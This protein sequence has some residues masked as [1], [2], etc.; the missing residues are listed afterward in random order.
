MSVNRK[1][2]R[3]IAYASTTYFGLELMDYAVSQGLA[4]MELYVGHSRRRD[5][6]G[7]LMQIEREHIELVIGKGT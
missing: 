2:P 6:T 1:Y 5:R 4:Q 7:Q 3:V